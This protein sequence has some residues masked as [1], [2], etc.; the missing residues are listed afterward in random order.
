MLRAFRNC[1]KTSYRHLL[2]ATMFVAAFLIK[3]VPHCSTYANY[4]PCSAFDKGAMNHHLR[5]SNWFPN[6]QSKNKEHL[7]FKGLS[8]TKLAENFNAS[9]FDKQL[10]NQ[11]TF[12]LIH[13]TGQYLKDL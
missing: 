5:H 1:A 9:A 13:I 7:T 3:D 6:C 10:L 4:G 2:S 12:N 8:Q 11:T